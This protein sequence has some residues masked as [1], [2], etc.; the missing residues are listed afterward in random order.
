MKLTQPERQILLNVLDR[1]KPMPRAW[2]GACPEGTKIRRSRT[3]SLPMPLGDT[4]DRMFQDDP[5]ITRSEHAQLALQL[6]FS[7]LGR[8]E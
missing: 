2:R 7:V 1:L 4:L 3:F 5:S 6:Y 8:D